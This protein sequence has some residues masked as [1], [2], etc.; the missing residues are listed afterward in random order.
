MLLAVV[1]GPEVGTRQ[2]ASY[3]DAGGVASFVLGGSKYSYLRRMYSFL[4]VGFEALLVLL[5]VASLAVGDGA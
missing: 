3:P 1:V 5:L 2:L 4:T